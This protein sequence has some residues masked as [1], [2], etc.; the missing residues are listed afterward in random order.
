MKKLSD[1]F[2]KINNFLN[3]NYFIINQPSAINFTFKKESK[4]IFISVPGFYM[5]FINNEIWDGFNLDK[6]SEDFAIRVS[7]LNNVVSTL[8]NEKSISVSKSSNNIVFNSGSSNSIEIPTVETVKNKVIKKCKDDCI[9]ISNSIMDDVLYRARA[10]FY[11]QNHTPIY[12]TIKIIS[13]DAVCRFVSGNGS[14]FCIQKIGCNIKNGTYCVPYSCLSFLHEL[15]KIIKDK[16]LNFRVDGNVFYVE[17]DS[18][19]MIQEHD[20]DYTKWPDE[21]KILNTECEISCLFDSDSLK[22]IRDNLQ[23]SMLYKKDDELLVTDFSIK[24]S[25][26]FS[27]NGKI[28]TNNSISYISSNNEYGSGIYT[29]LLLD[30][31]NSMPDIA[32]NVLLKTSKEEF[33]GKKFP[34]VVSFTD[35]DAEVEIICSLI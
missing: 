13:K 30:L 18:F 10:C 32:V 19:I 17:N 11:T 3:K 21:S 25:I 34:I 35:E 31:V 28:K 1:L 6:I 8:K 16:N 33:R 5:S 23:L 15:N 2:S 22:S 20:L 24:D 29:R 9:A 4:N 26:Y 12:N 14:L 7:D 27:T